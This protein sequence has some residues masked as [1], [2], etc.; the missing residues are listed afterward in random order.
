MDQVN[1]QFPETPVIEK[2]LKGSEVARLLNVSR[3]FA[4]LLLQSGDIPTVRLGR[5]VRVRPSDLV[6][7]ISQNTV[8]ETG[9]ISSSN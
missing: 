9:K 4:Y 8:G 2:L 6:D 3:S 7:F 1:T 5:S